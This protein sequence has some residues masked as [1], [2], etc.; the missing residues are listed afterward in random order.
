[1]HHPHLLRGPRP[2][3]RAVW[4]GLLQGMAV[5][6]LIAALMAHSQAQ[7]AAMDK[8][9]MHARMLD[10]SAQMQALKAS[11]ASA[12]AR[13][14]YQAAE[15]E[16]R[17]LSALMGGDAPRVPDLAV[18]R[19]G[20]VAKA[21]QA[22]VRAKVAPAT[23]PFCRPLTTTHT[24]STPL[25]I[26]TGPA[27]VTSTLV[28]SGAN[29]WLWDVDLTTFLTHSFSADL[30]ITLTSPAGTVVTLTTDNGSFNDNS[31]NG[32]VWDDSA[33][34]LVTDYTYVNLVAAPALV[35]EEAMSAFVGENPNGTWT[36][37][38]HD[39][40]ASDGGALDSWRLAITALPAAPQTQAINATQNTAM[41]IADAAT[42]HSDL[43]VSGAGA[44]I[45]EVKV[46]TFIEHP[47]SGDL[48]LRLISPAG[49]TVVLSTDNGEA[50]DNLFNG[51]AWFDKANP[52]GQVPYNG[53]SGLATDHPYVN[54][55]TAAQLAPEGALGAL[56]GQDPNGTWRL[57]VTDDTA[58][59]TGQ[60]TSWRL[61]ITTAACA[62]I[63]PVVIA[64][65]PPG[66][67]VAGA[68]YAPVTLAATGGVLPYTWT[69][70]SLPSGMS[71]NASTGELSGPPAV[72][73]EGS[74]TLTVTDN[75]A[76]Q[77]S[78]S[79]HILPALAIGTSTLADAV[80]GQPYS[81]PVQATG[82][83]APLS[84]SATG[85]P[86]GL[87]IDPVTGV[88]A[89]TPTDV[90]SARAA[91]AKAV[92]AVTV[93]VQDSSA[94]PVIAQQAFSLNVNVV[95]QPLAVTPVPTLG[96]W[97]LALLAALAAGL[98]VRAQRRRQGC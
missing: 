57:A 69:A 61:D 9:Q 10:L 42:S 12:S 2:S 21:L 92:L 19:Q 82:G 73:S 36:L 43:V 91:Q 52:A 15:Q 93:S 71:L 4:S 39:D 98:G 25:A 76:Q 1:M 55:T 87:A 97:A 47:F 13:G 65:A 70:P 27:V 56:M 68:A 72:G 22:P 3:F 16:Y 95:A 89:G 58:D 6:S 81:Q 66:P 84:W 50:L 49:S 30:D 38:I 37:T 60:L 44:A 26:P 34:D 94:T 86:A 5:L 74:Y 88:I 78:V 59:S 80:V 62:P 54:M 46:T 35:P 11:Q 53:N 90:K 32:T 33:S 63:T 85:L 45:L 51:T 64:S 20:A 14:P 96:D 79:V 31:F 8:T 48:D 28:V 83:L 41:P 29:P 17:E 75:A 24:Q 18:S 7:A 23:P 77:A 40:L 67:G